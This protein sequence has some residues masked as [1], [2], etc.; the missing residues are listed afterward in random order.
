MSYQTTPYEGSLRRAMYIVNSEKPSLWFTR[1]G[2]F[3]PKLEAQHT[4]EPWGDRTAY[5]SKSLRDPVTAIAKWID[6]TPI[7][8]DGFTAVDKGDH[9][10]LTL[11]QFVPYHY[12]IPLSTLKQL[13][14]EYDAAR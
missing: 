11:V 10:E 14:V 1:L 12:R 6:S 2:E 13:T 9:W 5:V 8:A 7:N 3:W 4:I